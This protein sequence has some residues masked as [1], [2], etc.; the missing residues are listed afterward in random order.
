MARSALMLSSRRSLLALPLAVFSAL[1]VAPQP[2]LAAFPGRDGLIAFGSD[3]GSQSLL[4]VAPSGAGLKV[5]ST[6]PPDPNAPCGGF[7]PTW[8]P[9][10]R[11][12]AFGR[13]SELWV[14][15]ADGSGAKRLE[16]VYGAEADWSPDGE[17]LVFTSLGYKG[18]YGIAIV[19][20]DGSSGRTLTTLVRDGSPTWSPDGRRIAFTRFRYEASGGQDIYT[21]SPS[22]KG[23]G[24]LIGDCYCNQPDFS[25]DGRHL[26]FSIGTTSRI[27]V[28][29]A[30]GTGR[31]R[32][33]SGIG[34]EP[35][36]SP[37]GRYIAFRRGEDLYVMR[38]DGSRLR[39]IAYNRSKAPIGD[40]NAD[41]EN[42][43][44]QPLPR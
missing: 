11:R 4:A 9:D 17:R 44:W 32:L 16:G 6:C 1:F 3:S 30:D 35:A 36:W 2:S 34:A 37:S 8:S 38:R 21:I 28:A 25:P 27:H 7:E 15:R 12:I 40:R 31:R 5:L 22:G 24:R 42:P 18:R 43:S 13:G 20:A 41:W 23:R 29:R 39:R 26:A 10:G 14:M 19:R 33:T